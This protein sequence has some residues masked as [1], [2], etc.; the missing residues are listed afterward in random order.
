M[1]PQT[2]DDLKSDVEFEDIPT[3]TFKLDMMKQTLSGFIDELDAIKQAVYLILNVERY[4]HLIY[5][6]N[7]GVELQ[8]LF[9]QPPSFVIPEIKRRITEALLQ[10]ER[11]TAVDG[12]SFKHLKGKVSA[13]FTVKTIYGEF[14]TEKVV[15]S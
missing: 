10:D 15:N 3:N 2:N 8:D 1:I 5:S 13:I 11:I 14:E 9:G 4:E 6:W 7:Y 12:F